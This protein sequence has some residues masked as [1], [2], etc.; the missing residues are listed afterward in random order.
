MQQDP[1]ET[2][3][4]LNCIYYISQKLSEGVFVNKKLKKNS[5]KNYGTP[6]FKKKNF[7]EK[8]INHF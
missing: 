1:H 6:N 8:M 7:K 4:L 5:I 2:K 3:K